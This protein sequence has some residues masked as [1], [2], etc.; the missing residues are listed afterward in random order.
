MS[1]IDFTATK[2]PISKA[3]FIIDQE[4]IVRDNGRQ[5]DWDAMLGVDAAEEFKFGAVKVEVA[6]DADVGDTSV[7]MIALLKALIKGQILNFG[8][9][10]AISVVL[11]ANVAEGATSM[12]VTA[13]LAE[14]PSGTLIDFGEVAGF[15]V[16]VAAAGASATDTSI[17]VDALPGRV[18]SGTTLHFGTN[19]Y[20]T[21]DADAE[22][23]ATTLSVLAIPTALVDADSASFKAEGQYV[24]TSADAILG[25]TSITIEAAGAEMDSGETGTVPKEQKL[26]V[27]NAAAALGATS[28]TVKA[29]DFELLDG[30]TAFTPG[31]GGFV[32]PAGQFVDL[33]ASGK[34]VPSVL[35]TAGVTAYGVLIAL[36]DQDSVVD[37]QTGYGL[38]VQGFFFENLLP[39]ADKAASPPVVPAAFK[40]EVLARGGAWMFQQYAD[41]TA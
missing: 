19:K 33:L 20:C 21:L 39:E 12:T 23:S 4:S 34:I 40:T 10:A 26:V 7:P 27:V 16:D 31:T 37:S 29:L 22:A 9:R 8:L 24:K 18:P 6:T 30:E 17:P 5:I 25:A 36:A 32:I 1:T 15:T 28:I 41:D 3:P 2:R 14:I 35:G 13:L 38:A 11:T